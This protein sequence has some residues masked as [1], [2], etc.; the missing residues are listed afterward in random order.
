MSLYGLGQDRWSIFSGNF[1][2]GD[3]KMHGLHTWDVQ[4][5]VK[6]EI[7][8][9]N[10]QK[11]AGTT[12]GAHSVTSSAEILAVEYLQLIDTLGDGF[13]DVPFDIDCTYIE[14][15]G[16]GVLNVHATDVKIAKHQ[17]KVSNDG[18]ELVYS[19]EF[20]I[21]EPIKWNGLQIIARDD[22]YWEASG[23]TIFG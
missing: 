4:E 13:S 12:R 2:F 5:E 19:V 11:G 22:A 10:R 6:R 20:T 23:L 14:Q 7:V 16:D 17:K 18:K 8:R 3:V 21:V 1:R 9:G 15:N